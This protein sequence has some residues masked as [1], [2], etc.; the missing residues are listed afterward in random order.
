MN[1]AVWF[2]AGLTLLTGQGAELRARE[3]ARMRVLVDRSHEWL[4]AH[5][6]LSERMLRPAGFEIVMCDASLDTTAKFKDFDIVFV[7]QAAGA[8]PFSD[9]E[10]AL[11]K[12]FVDGGGCLIVVG[13]PAGP[14]A[15]VAG[16]FGFALN[17]RNCRLPLRSEAWL[18]DSFGAERELRTRPMSCCV[19][20]NGEARKLITDQD[21]VAVAILK[22]YGKGKV[23]CFADN[24]AHWDFCT[25]ATKTCEC[26]MCRR[27][28]HYSS[29]WCRIVR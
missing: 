14:S 22:E 20:A 23:L 8:F 13:N 18:R 1:R 6:D 15:G 25:N 11:L 7:Q 3:A 26:P 29:A 10:R 16:D 24:G 21:G 12:R 19:D 5:D 28:S 9:D 27:L 2:L 17:S 4:F